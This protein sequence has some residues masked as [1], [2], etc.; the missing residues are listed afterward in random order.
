MTKWDIAHWKVFTLFSKI[1]CFRWCLKRHLYEGKWLMSYLRSLYQDF[2]IIM[3]S[4]SPFATRMQK[5]SVAEDQNADL[6]VE[7][8]NQISK[9]HR[10]FLSLLKHT[11]IVDPQW[12]IVEPQCSK[13][14][15]CFLYNQWRLGQVSAYPQ[16]L[17][18]IHSPST[19]RKARDVPSGKK[20]HLQPSW[21]HSH[22]PSCLIKLFLY[23]MWS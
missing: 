10:A 16:P 18:S 5:T 13:R 8:V 22:F 2:C 15:S 21:Y 1:V 9:C 6:H 12:C 11:C 23:Q 4:N 20:Q 14:G 19:L 17:L 7:I 3:R